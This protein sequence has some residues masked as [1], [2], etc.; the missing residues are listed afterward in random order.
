[1]SQTWK[2]LL[3]VVFLG[4]VTT[5]VLGWLLWRQNQDQVRLI[6]E[7]A[8]REAKR[9][10]DALAELRT[11]YTANV[12]DAARKHGLEIT[13]DYRTKEKAI[14]L[15]ATF[16]M[17][18][19]N[20]ITQ[21]GT[22]GKTRL[23]SAYPFP[24][25]E[26]TG[27]LR[28]DFG[29]QAWE[30]LNQNPSEP[31]SRI[32]EVD[33]ARMF[34]YAL[35]DRMRERCVSCHNA[36]PDNPARGIKEWK[37]GDVR[38]VLEVAIPL[39]A[40]LAQSQASVKTTGWVLAGTMAVWLATLG[41]MA[42]RRRSQPPSD[43]GQASGLK[44]PVDRPAAAQPP[45]TVHQRWGFLVAP[46][47]ALMNRLTYP[48]KFLL[49]S[50]LFVLPLGLVMYFLTTEINDRIGFAAKEILGNRYLRPLRVLSEEVAESRVL[51]EAI[52]VQ[53]GQRPELVRKQ[54]DIEEALAAVAAVDDKLGEQLK[55]TSKLRI[56]QENWRLLKHKLSNLDI[57]DSEALHTH[58]LAD[59]RAL[60]LHV[61]D[62]SNL[63]LDPDLDSYYVMDAVLLKLPEGQD[64]LASAALFGQKKLKKGGTIT[65]EDRA[66]FTR[67]EG[68][69]RSNMEATRAGMI[70]AFKNNPAES[71]RPQLDK[72]V[73]DHVAATEAFLEV[74]T[75][76][77]IHATPVRASAEEY[78]RTSRAAIRT[79]RL[80]FDKAI[81]ELDVLLEA[82][83][84]GFAHKRTVVEIFSVV[85]LIFVVYLLVAFY[86]AVMRIVAGLREA[87]DR[88][89]KG[90]VDQVVTLDTRDEL[91]QVVTSFNK[92][93]FRLRDEWTQA[94]D[95]SARARIAEAQL[96]EHEEELVHAKE[97]AEEANRSKS[98]FLA[99]MS[100]ELRT[101]L[102]AIIGYS[103]M[104]QETAEDVGQS[105]FIPDLKKIHGSG[106][107]LLALINDILDL[108]KI[109]A[110]K[111][112]LFSETIDVADLVQDV[113]TT[114]HPLVQKNGN[115]LEIQA[116]AALGTLN[117]DLTKV[118]QCLF[119]LLS[120]AC[121][122]TERG[123]VRLSVERMTLLDR[124]WFR[125][126]VSDTGIGMTPEQMGKLFQAFS[127]ADAS[128]TRKYGGTGLG[129]ALSRRFCQLMGGDITVA[130]KAG[131]GSTFTMQLPAEP[132]APAVTVADVKPARTAPAPMAPH[133]ETVLVVDDEV[134]VLDL[135]TRYLTR[136]GFHVVT[137]TTGAEA[138]PLARQTRPCAITLDV[139]MPGMDGW[140]VLTAL[141][142]DPQLADIPVIMCT[143]VDD[144]TMGYA[145]GATEYLVKPIDRKRLAAIL[146][147]YRCPHPPCPVLLVEDHAPTRALMAQMLRGAGWQVAEAE[148]GRSALECVAANLPA[149]ILL[150]LMMPVMDG[151]EFVRQLRKV[152]AY[153]SIPVVIVTAKDLTEEDTKQLYGHVTAILHKGAYNKDDLLREV[154]DLVRGCLTEGKPAKPE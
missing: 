8:R 3:P 123:T 66:E 33:G 52:L 65:A 60:Y 105:D 120:N 128:T 101:P 44:S 136:E 39:D 2:P 69:L 16:S 146:K 42:L 90:S 133:A 68:L 55:S 106:K 150:D 1:M 126:Q 111:M 92:V 4:L 48:R 83:I 45:V 132:S 6:E 40:A 137:A 138:L 87:S 104:L 100:H 142:N 140:A 79:N 78:A 46:A 102:N 127:Q 99:N 141:K 97:G 17:E 93:A 134:A 125:F 31:F 131:Q 73:Y 84:A 67:L 58:L 94:R 82:R 118:R 62:T 20:Q 88:M 96:R 152:Q 121:K 59:N 36:H 119:N 28:D 135:M 53:A 49:I 112:T 74:M 114:V 56:V 76:D 117:A 145:L 61:G 63:I 43:G 57:K 124:A 41:F 18:L 148:N 98:Q 109:E 116:G 22:G 11:M 80:L 77:I 32:E 95:E 23:Y 103:E 139:M 151:F 129:L 29:R 144:K 89:M 27:G 115:T 12:V 26:A 38:G 50:I 21:R 149:L 34:R 47:V 35:A 122:F 64:L 86:V 25:R 5:A 13:H 9:Y 30:A 19:G 154:G 15:P 70:V 153:R 7:T 14:P 37:E 81:K 107:H 10:A 147:K 85:V 24:W 54:A 75:R 130:S 110:G 51:A 143:M 72:L 91:G 113:A 71:L 108:S